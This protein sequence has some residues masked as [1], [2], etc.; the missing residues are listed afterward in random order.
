MID[1]VITWVDGADPVWLEKK[2]K[3]TGVL[4]QNSDAVCR[5]RDWD[6]LR[7]WFRGVD[8]FAPWVRYVYFV[9]DDQKP[10][11]LNTDNPRLKWVKHTDFIPQEYLPTFNSNAIEWNLHRIPGLSENFVYFNDDVFLIRPVE[12]EDF[13]SGG[14][15]CDNPGVNSILPA[16]PFEQILFQNGL[17]INK[18]FSLKQSLRQHWKKWARCQSPVGV[19]KLLWYGRRDA[20]PG[21]T[22]NHIHIPYCKETFQTLWEMEG[23]RIHETCTH[24]LRTTDD[25]NHFCIRDWRNLE[26]K[27]YP[28][29]P[30]GKQFS[31]SDLAC[32][33]EML[34]Y[35]KRQK[36]KVICIND[37]EK[38]VDFER[39]RQMIREAFETILPERSSFELPLSY[40]ECI[41]AASA[42]KK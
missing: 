2:A 40:A 16:A 8:K 21:T 18:H 1:F 15:P 3:H 33:D 7:Y 32:G 12:P 11:W 26:G 37:G 13:F 28:R 19:L 27:F 5:Y 34:T 23:A 17:L 10:E 14:L 24:K 39:H 22:Y 25:V 6:F 42:R 35:L 4:S 29:K 31:T 36:G 20:L 41:T 38:E 9:T 30:L